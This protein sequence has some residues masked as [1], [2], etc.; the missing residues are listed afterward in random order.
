MQQKWSR[1]KNA[2]AQREKP[3]SA[4]WKMNDKTKMTSWPKKFDKLYK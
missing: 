4:A 2:G 3:N 1:F